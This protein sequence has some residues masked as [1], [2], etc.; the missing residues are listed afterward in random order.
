MAFQHNL[1]K[2]IDLPVW[3]WLRFLPTSASH[4]ATAC[5]DERGTNRFIYFLLGSTSFWRY[6]T[7]TD[8][9]QQLANPPS[10]TFGQGVT[11]TFDPSR[12]YIWLFAPLSSSPYNVFAYYDIANNTWVSRAAVSGLSSQWGTDAVLVHTCTSY[13]TAGNDDYIYLIG[14]SSTTWYRYSISANTWTTMTPALPASALS[15]CGLIWTFGFN[16]DRLYYIRGGGTNSIYYFSISGNTWTTLTY[17]PATETFTTGT[18]YAY[19]TLN[20]IYIQKDNTHRIFYLQL[21]ENIMYP[22]PTA[23]YTAGSAVVGDGLIYIKTP[24]GAEYLYFRRHNSTEF[25]RTLI[26]W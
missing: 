7:W 17:Q 9:F 14:N 6:D 19:D 16:A 24:D 13:N 20:R 12:N 26:F 15:G 18:T 23:P 8:T 22:G 1:K 11:M 5:T 4:G 10:L 25:W 21:D 3:Q 2:G